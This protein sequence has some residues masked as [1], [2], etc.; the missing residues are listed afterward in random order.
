MKRRGLVL[1]R[2]MRRRAELGARQAYRRRVRRRGPGCNLY[3]AAVRVGWRPAPA[4]WLEG[5]LAVGP[6]RGPRWRWLRW[7]LGRLLSWL[8][9]RP[10]VV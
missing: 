8:A 1:A 6:E 5:V 2:L 10:R 4:D 3:L 7:I 9:V